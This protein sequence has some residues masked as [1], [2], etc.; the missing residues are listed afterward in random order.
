MADAAQRKPTTL[1]A[2]RRDGWENTLTAI[3]TTRDKRT[4][5]R[6]LRP[7]PN[8]TYREFEDL[9]FASDLAATAAELPAREMV[10]AWIT[11][12]ADNPSVLE[13]DTGSRT[14]A[15]D[16]PT[17]EEKVSLGNK[18]ANKLDELEA[19]A[20]VFEAMVWARVFGGGL[21][22][23]GI[24]DGGGDNPEAMAEPLDEDNIQ[25]FNHLTVFDRW[26]VNI[27][28][29]FSDPRDVKFGQPEQYRLVSTTHDGTVVPG[30]DLI[31]ESRFIRFD[32]VLTNRRRM[33]DNGGWSD[34]IYCRT[35][36]LIRDFDLAWHGIAN[37][38][39]DFAQAIF[40]M[41][42]LRDAIL[43]DKD[44]LVLRRMGIIDLCRS[45]GRAIPI[46]AEDE[47]FGRK[48]TPVTGMPDL[49]D[50]FALRLSAAFRQ[51]ATLLFGQSPAGMQATG[52]SD[53]RFFYDQ[54]AANQETTLRPRLE[55]LIKL[56][57]LDKD[58]PTSGREPEDW[59]FSFNPL[60]QLTELEQS[61][62]RHRQAQTD[63]IYVTEGVV[64]EDEVA[65]S[66]FGGDRYNTDTILDLEQR[67]EDK[68]ADERDPEPVPPP[69]G[70]PPIVPGAPP[71][72]PPAPPGTPPAPP[73]PPGGNQ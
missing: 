54:I 8:V 55:R 44:D 50:R 30:T 58:G 26:D 73:A 6:L 11:I 69:P 45:I 21:L 48:A 29:R 15:G 33:R 61:E 64:S 67:E 38:L 14:E 10:R 70:M 57:T 9:Y 49:M 47:E 39:Q 43:S 31:H 34:S 40:K 42:G 71:G 19:Q 3:G 22:F 12:V 27:A 37:L 18:I 32:G 24:D 28:K 46:D 63:Q 72:Q 16:D 66:R 51:P 1:D 4:G 41:R 7:V 35:K 17:T 53:I 59:S 65:F 2:G 25:S 36:D 23:L 5:G 68:L 62:L 20:K 60:F 52:A 56:V 13:K